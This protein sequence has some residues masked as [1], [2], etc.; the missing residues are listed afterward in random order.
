MSATV[1][2]CRRQGL[3]PFLKSALELESKQDLRAKNQRS[4]FI[5][6]CLNFA[7]QSHRR[8]ANRRLVETNRPAGSVRPR[9]PR[10]GSQTSSNL[11][12][13]FLRD[14]AHHDTHFVH[15]RRKLVRAD[16]HFCVQ[17]RTSYTSFILIRSRSAAPRLLRSSAT[18][19]PSYLR[20]ASTH[21]TFRDEHHR[22]I[23]STPNR[24]TRSLSPPGPGSCAGSQPRHRQDPRPGGASYPDASWPPFG[25]RGH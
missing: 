25:S 9:G 24:Y 10:S 4:G 1:P 2:T 16:F 21:H 15:G 6:R 18:F 11:L 8:S 22:R 13:K 19:S 23:P 14:I 20:L 3:K 17:Y 7:N 12:A 5:Q